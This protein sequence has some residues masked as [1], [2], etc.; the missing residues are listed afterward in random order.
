MGYAVECK[1]QAI[2]GR[3]GVD[4]DGLGGAA[5]SAFGYAGR[6]V[7]WGEQLIA[8]LEVFGLSDPFLWGARVATLDNI[9]SMF[10]D[11]GRFAPWLDEITAEFVA[12]AKQRNVA[13]AAKS[14]F[15]S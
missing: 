6:I 9:T 10:A 3:P 5:V 4:L 15:E 2:A 1:V 12:E 14:A 8:V 7:K 11:P 13:A